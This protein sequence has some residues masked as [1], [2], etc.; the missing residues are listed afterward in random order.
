YSRDGRYLAA[1]LGRKNGIRIFET[2]GYSE[3]VRETA[4]DDNCFWV[5]FDGAGRLVTASDDGFIRLYGPNFHLLRKVKPVTGQHP[6]SARFSPDGRLI[7]IGFDDSMAVTVISGVDLSRRYELRTPSGGI[8]EN[9]FTPL[10]STDGEDVCA[11]GRYSH[12][13]INPV[14]CWDKQG[15]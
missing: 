10:W 8:D 15:K 1:A 14:L 6:L 13:S 4:Y 5:E 12:G 9:I 2:A 7:A 3:F 11:A